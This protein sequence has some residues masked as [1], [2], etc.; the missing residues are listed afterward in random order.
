MSQSSS[1]RS[2]QPRDAARSATGGSPRPSGAAPVATAWH[3]APPSEI[4][5]VDD[6]DMM[7]AAEE[8]TIGHRRA[9]PLSP[10]FM[11]HPLKTLCWFVPPWGPTINHPT[12]EVAGVN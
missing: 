1:I 5:V 2:T 12:S 11:R 9:E 8:T 3:I 4:P 6:V 7:E 10:N